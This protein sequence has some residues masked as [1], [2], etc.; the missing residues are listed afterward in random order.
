LFAKHTN[1]QSILSLILKYIYL[2][3]L[4]VTSCQLSF[5][6]MTTFHLI[7]AGMM[8]CCQSC[9]GNCRRL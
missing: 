7:P 4:A 9:H 3:Y 5:S 8:L 6:C 1:W 2:V